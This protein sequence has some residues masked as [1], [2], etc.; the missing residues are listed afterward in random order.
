MAIDD[1]LRENDANIAEATKQRDKILRLQRKIFY[2]T[3]FDSPGIERTV[4]PMLAA[5]AVVRDRLA[6]VH[7][8]ILTIQD[9]LRAHAGLSRQLADAGQAMDEL[10]RYI[11]DP[12]G[13][14]ASSNITYH[15]DVTSLTNVL[16][17]MQALSLTALNAVRASNSIAWTL[18]RR[19][20]A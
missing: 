20:R 5:L 4:G 19:A 17:H 14:A 11:D 9:E 12:M 18:F 7:A 1:G 8:Q 10:G 6:T 16:S 15:S 2:G 13:Y 3:T